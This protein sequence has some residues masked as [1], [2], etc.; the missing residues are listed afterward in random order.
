MQC[1]AIILAEIVFLDDKN[2]E[3]IESIVHTYLGA[4]FGIDYTDNSEYLLY[5]N[6]GMDPVSQDFADRISDLIPSSNNDSQRDT[7][8]D[9]QLGWFPSDARRTKITTWI[10]EK[11]SLLKKVAQSVRVEEDVLSHWI[12]DNKLL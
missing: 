9:F 3:S 7:F 11:N 12:A 10:P 4:D 8:F 6:R 2:L 5:Y 1:C